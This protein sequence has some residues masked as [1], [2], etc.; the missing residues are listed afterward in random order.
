MVFLIITLLMLVYCIYIIFNIKISYKLEGQSIELEQQKFYNAAL[1]NTLNNIRR[2]K[3]GYNNNL[4][5]LYAF[6]KLGQ[7][8]EL[9]NY[10]NEV[11]EMNNKLSDT[12]IL[13]IKNAA[14]YGLVASKIQYAEDKGVD[15]KVSTNSEIKDIPNIRMIDLC[16]ILGIFLDNAIEAAME[17]DE[18][19]VL[20]EIFENFEY[21][22]IIVKN[23]FKTYPDMNKIWNKGFSPKGEKRG[24]G[25]WIVK[26]ILKS[27]KHILNNTYIK[28]NMFYQ[29]LIIE[30]GN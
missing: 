2:F 4:N 17:S 24:M 13:D 16:E 5:V 30:K 7:Y 18:K 8:D 10:F 3:H 25:L 11:M 28:D 6:A 14:L 9:L 21:I 12:T 22:G 1:D 15:F 27:N 26:E 29:E 19:T 20:M 23:T